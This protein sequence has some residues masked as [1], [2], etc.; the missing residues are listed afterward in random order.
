[1]HAQKQRKDKHIEVHVWGEKK[2]GSAM[3]MRKRNGPSKY[4]EDFIITHNK[5]YGLLQKLQLAKK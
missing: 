4:S 3:L 5:V 2:G 1:V